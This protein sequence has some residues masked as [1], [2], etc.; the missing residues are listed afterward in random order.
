[1]KATLTRV[2]QFGVQIEGSNDW[3]NL[4]KFDNVSLE[5]F[6]K[7][8][9]V[10]IELQKDKYITKL[11][12]VGS[13]TTSDVPPRTNGGQSAKPEGNVINRQSAAKTVFGSPSVANA[14]KDMDLSEVTQNL[15]ELT[16]QLE[17]YIS[18]GSFPSTPTT[19]EPTPEQ[20]KSL[21][22]YK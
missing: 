11:V 10:E 12:K 20:L 18:N 14:T 2:S 22:G 8:D 15:K 5:G 19:S 1:M 7:G 16:V 13:S 21:A 3:K 6:Q 9:Q 4:S 17:Y